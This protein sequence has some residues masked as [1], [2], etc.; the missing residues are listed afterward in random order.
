ML[1]E[2]VYNIFFFSFH[3]RFYI[4]KEI[5]RFQITE[6]L[7]KLIDV[8]CTGSVTPEQI[9]DFIASISNPRYIFINFHHSFLPKKQV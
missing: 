9:M 6:K 7:L 8:E 5:K 3:I 1:K 2:Y 4:I